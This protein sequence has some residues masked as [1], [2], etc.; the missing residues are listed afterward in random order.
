MLGKPMSSNVPISV[1][2]TSTQDN[3]QNTNTRKLERA[4]SDVSKTLDRINDILETTG[5]KVVVKD[6]DDSVSKKMRR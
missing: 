3:N 6:I 1:A 4:M 5:A 2:T